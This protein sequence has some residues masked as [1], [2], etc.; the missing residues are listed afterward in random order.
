[1]ERL[2]Q[3]RQQKRKAARSMEEQ[4]AKREE[5]VRRKRGVLEMDLG[6]LKSAGAAVVKPV[7]KVNRS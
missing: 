4:I 6:R 2:K 7:K 5:W 1:M 3:A